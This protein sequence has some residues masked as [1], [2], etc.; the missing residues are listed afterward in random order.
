MA[1]V[2]RDDPLSDSV[3]ITVSRPPGAKGVSGHGIVCTLTFLA[4]TS[5]RF[6][7]SITKGA[8]IQPGNQS[9]PVSGSEI[10]VS[11]Q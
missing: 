9:A 7:V 4:K 3:E 5:G 8:V 11:V 10:T 1:L 6:P 2:H